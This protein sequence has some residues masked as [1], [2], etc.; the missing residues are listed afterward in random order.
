MRDKIKK[1]PNL[2][3]SKT[4][5]LFLYFSPLLCLKLL[6]SNSHCP[7]EPVYTICE[8]GKLYCSIWNYPSNSNDVHAAETTNL[9]TGLFTKSGTIFNHSAVF[10]C[11][12]FLQSTFPARLSVP[13][14]EFQQGRQGWGEI[15][16]QNKFYKYSFWPSTSKRI[17]TAS[18]LNRKI[19]QSC[20]IF[21]EGS[22]EQKQPG[23]WNIIS[24]TIL[25]SSP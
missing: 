17:K 23:I 11:V 19:L 24:H 8:P 21:L 15:R 16:C 14:A 1:I 13:L 20:R 18:S 2:C 4:S 5:T 12:H 25:S 7:D 3:C 22:R 9:K 10:L 6:C